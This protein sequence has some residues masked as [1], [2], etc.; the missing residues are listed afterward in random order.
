[1]NE[2]PQISVCMP[3]YNVEDYIGEAIESV[4][5]QS[6]LDFE[7]IM[8]NDGSTDRSLSIVQNYEDDRIRIVNSNHDYIK[9]LNIGLENAR[10]R[11]I[12]RMD[13]DDKMHEN[14]I[15]TQF[16]YLECNKDI[17]ACGAGFERF[18]MSVNKYIPKHLN[19]D[20]IEIAFL[21]SNCFTVGMIRKDFIDANNI[22]YNSQ[23]VYAEDY[24][25]WCDIIIAG[26]KLENLPQILYY[27]R[28]HK[29]QIS[30][31]FYDDMIN[32]SYV[33][34]KDI[35]QYLLKN[36]TDKYQSVQLQVELLYDL[37][38]KQIIKLEDYCKIVSC[39]I[40]S[41]E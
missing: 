17:A 14:R 34:K 1:M 2:A 28:E 18:G 32:K 15:L 5:N 40:L 10:G 26:G 8:I 25:L 22:C 33:I 37:Y 30:R 21:E 6:F 38:I 39:L 29:K 16:N 9:S 24:R 19:T 36:K 20:E 31:L 12:A 13:A 35:I 3:F 4:L 23:F 11:Y 7:L 41:Q 27:Y